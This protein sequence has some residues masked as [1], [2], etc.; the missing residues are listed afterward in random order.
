MDTV[1]LS[2]HDQI[3]HMKTKG[4]KFELFSEEKAYHFLQNNSY[5]FK[6][7]A[8]AKNYDKYI[9]G[10]KRGQYINLDFAYLVELSTIDSHLR[11]FILKL[12]LDIEHHLKLKLVRDCCNNSHEDGYSIVTEYLSK[13]LRIKDDLEYKKS[14]YTS[15]T[16]DLLAKYME[17]LAV[18]N[19]V[20]VLSFGDF[21]TLYRLYY[22][23]YPS[24]DSLLGFLWSVRFLRN[25]AAHNNCLLNS[26]KNPYSRITQNKAI[27]GVISKNSL[28][29]PSERA[30]KM[31]NPVIADF[32]ITL[33]VFRECVMSDTIRA[34]TIAELKTL[35]NDRAQKHKDYF[36]KNNSI[37][38]SFKFVKK[39]VD[40]LF[41]E[42]I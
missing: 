2:I 25:A 36:V 12:C 30:N 35:L 39:N 32:I 19:I 18:W 28:I 10:D 11:K 33:Y 8:Y 21:L 7:K 15:A 37:T 31:S 40:F 1:K 41:P 38:S 9:K 23:K 16:R 27:T 20:E 34:K 29:S 3:S 14:S 42:S 24:D 22:Q 13:N 4:Y 26:L 5:Y 17:N 6:I